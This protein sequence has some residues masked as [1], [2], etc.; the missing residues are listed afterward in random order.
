[1]EGAGLSATT[2]GATPSP[3][4]LLVREAE[5]AGG[6]WLPVG[7]TEAAGEVEGNEMNE[8]EPVAVGDKLGF[9]VLEGEGVREGTGD[10][11]GMGRRLSMVNTGPTE[12]M[13]SVTVYENEVVPT[14]PSLS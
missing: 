11:D 9:D 4:M 6:D 7:A 5:G 3:A 10:V 1:M 13:P 12:S 2:G 8:R 14:N